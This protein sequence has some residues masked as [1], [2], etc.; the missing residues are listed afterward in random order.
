MFIEKGFKLKCLFLKKNL[1][2]KGGL[3]LKQP[4]LSKEKIKYSF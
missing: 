4:G 2:D 1:S 3:Q